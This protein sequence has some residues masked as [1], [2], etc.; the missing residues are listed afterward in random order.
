MMKICLLYRGCLRKTAIKKK[1]TVPKSGMNAS[2]SSGIKK[3]YAKL[4]EH[5]GL[6][7]VV[8]ITPM[9]AD[10]LYDGSDTRRKFADSILSQV[11]TS[12]LNALIEY[13]KALLN[14]NAMLKQFNESRTW[15]DTLLATFDDILISRGNSIFQKE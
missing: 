9:D 4:S 12:Y 6:L 13:N 5:I 10:L 15:D 8:M 7:P 3:D 14:R 11:D 2:N 1:F